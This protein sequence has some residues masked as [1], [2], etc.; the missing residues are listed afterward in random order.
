MPLACVTLSSLCVP[1]AAQEQRY[2][3]YALLKMGHDQTQIAKCLE[4]H[5]S[6]I[7]RELGRNQGQ[8]GYRPKQ[9][10]KKALK[11]RNQ[12]AKKRITAETW[13]Q[14]EEKLRVDWSPEQISGWMKKNEEDTIS[15]ESIY[16]Y[17]YADKRTGGDLHKHLRCQKK[18]RKRYGGKDRRGKIPNR[19][20]IEERPEIVELR[21]RIGDWEADTIIGAGKK[22]AIVT[23]VERKSRFTLLDKVDR[24]TA[25]ATEQ[26]IVRMLQPLI[27]QVLTVTFDNGKEFANHEKIAQQL[28][29]KMYFA[30]PYASWERG[31]N[32]NTNGLIRQYL[33][34][35]SDFSSAN[36]EQI[37][38]IKERLNHRPRKCLDFQTPAMVFSQLD[39]GCT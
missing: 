33:P 13:D 39:P 8:R 11:R 37:S 25:E 38:F 20:S 17:V 16:R 7:S 12:K 36:D 4:V 22:G 5:K 18:Y 29:A 3:I 9:A 14:I 6:T 2:Q 21:E 31:T 27:F 15:H 30:H 24:R 23:L 19:V 10:N 32:E 35:G 26:A 28:Q 34:K 1:M